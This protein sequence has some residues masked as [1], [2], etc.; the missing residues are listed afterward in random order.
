MFVLVIS[1][2]TS[3]ADELDVTRGLLAQGKTAAAFEQMQVYTAKHP[4]DIQGWFLLGWAAQASQQLNQAIDAYEKLLQLRPD[5]PEAYNN[6]AVLYAARGDD[7]RARDYLFTAL[8]THPSY[9]LAYQNL[10][11]LYASLASNAYNRALNTQTDDKVPTLPL[12]PLT[13]IE[14]VDDA[15]APVRGAGEGPAEVKRQVQEM[16]TAWAHAWSKADADHYLKFYAPQFVLP[17]GVARGDWEAQ[18]RAR[19][20]SPR[21]IEVKLRQV[22]VRPLEESSLALANF[23]Q[24]YRSDN[25]TDTV[26]KFLVV[27]KLGGRWLIMQEVTGS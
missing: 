21:F 17:D 14:R 22:D 20:S 27:K 13:P 23:D 2:N 6:L 16:L 11:Q 9:A 8:N 25:F 26:K 3:L 10:N 15:R 12:P 4:R 24:L 5:L 1:T 19:L 18:R 7:K